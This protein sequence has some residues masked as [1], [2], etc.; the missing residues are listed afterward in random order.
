M[1]MTPIPPGSSGDQTPSTGRRLPLPRL[2]AYVGLGLCA[3]VL[4]VALLVLMF[5]GAIL[6]S[7]GKRKAERAV[8]SA[9]PG[10]TLQIGR[11]EYAVGANRLVASSVALSTAS[12]TL[13]VSRVSLTGCRWSR[14]LLRKPPLA[15]LLA[16]A[17]LDAA[18]VDLKLRAS[19]YGI[20]CARLRASAPDSALIADGFELGPLVGDEELFADAFRKTRFRAVVTECRV[21]GLD[22][23]ELLGGKAYRA[24]SISVSRP[25]LDI[26]VDRD[27]PVD[28]S[29]KR[30]LMVHEALA[31]IRR[32]LQLDALEV[33]DGHVTYAE[34]VAAGARPGVLT[35]SA[36]GV[37][38]DG[39][40]NRGE[41]AAIRLRAHG[42]FM[43]AGLLAVQMTIPVAPAEFSFRY[44]GSLGPMDLTRLDA[45]LAVAEHIR[46]KSG[47]AA[48]V[49][50][51][52]AVDG[53]RAHGQV[54]ATYRDLTISILDPHTGAE[55]GP[56]SLMANA[57]RIRNA[58][59]PEASGAMKVGRV[60]FTRRP[61]HEFLQFA[62]FALRSGV[63]DAI[64]F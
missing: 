26:L 41:A 57:L 19:R 42:R 54:R 1:P 31:S 49:T 23:G 13:A 6:N 11:L 7:Y 2:A 53:G 28:P 27:K 17:D 58:N 12:S 38:A 8:A 36:V 61:E 37:S 14:L 15:D 4:A 18:G 56:S 5:G 43:G 3:L 45:F 48:G 40:A 64:S 33:A 10:Y 35:F 32:P 30:P 50:F 51:E 39:I 60:E 20:R 47:T 22:F 25:N 29:S 21:S 46:V 55:K 34:R 24:R 9:L 16:G 52:I 59:A 63:L 44:S 62:W